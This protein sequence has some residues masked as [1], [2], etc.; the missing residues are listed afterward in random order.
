MLTPEVLVLVAERFKALAEPARLQILNCLRGGELTVTEL[1][2][3]TEFGQA[4][5]SKHLQL[6]HTLGF[7]N[8]RKE[9][10]YV[11]YALADK[12]VFQLCDVMC[13][14]L[15]AEMKARRKLLAG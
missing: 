13:G 1:V 15:E 3:E 2:E 4:N 10:L 6:L 8:R 7:V 5:V 14:R 11:Y 9:G 12:S